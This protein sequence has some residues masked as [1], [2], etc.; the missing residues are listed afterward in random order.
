[1]CFGSPSRLTASLCLI[2][3]KLQQGAVECREKKTLCTSNLF[4]VKSTHPNNQLNFSF[5]FL[6][7]RFDVH[8]SEGTLRPDTSSLQSADQIMWPLTKTIT[9]STERFRLHHTVFLR[10]W[11]LVHFRDFSLTLAENSFST[12]NQH[13]CEKK[14]TFLISTSAKKHGAIQ[15]KA[16]EQLQSG[17]WAEII[18]NTSSGIPPHPLGK[19]SVA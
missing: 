5:P 13:G 15:S 17:P 18:A 4:I 1:M 7:C 9:R 19:S 2:L 3:S 11:S 12:T 10:S 6:S 16:P 14:R 8:L